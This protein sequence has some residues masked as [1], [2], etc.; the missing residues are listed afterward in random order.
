[1][2]DALVDSS[3][4]VQSAA[5]PAMSAAVAAGHCTRQLLLVLDST[6]SGSDRQRLLQ[7]VSAVGEP[8]SRVAQRSLLRALEHDSASNGAAAIALARSE[9][10]D[11]RTIRALHVAFEQGRGI[12]RGEALIALLKLE[13]QCENIPLVREALLDRDPMMRRLAIE[14]LEPILLDRFL[15]CPSARAVIQSVTAD[16]S[17]EVRV[18][19]FR[20]L[21]AINH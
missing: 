15:P 3:Q 11:S 19:A 7:I 4:R 16:T 18:A 6:K 13:P 5:M 21:A 1:M 12:A 10:R 17:A 20:M 8:L 9:S 2:F 14:S